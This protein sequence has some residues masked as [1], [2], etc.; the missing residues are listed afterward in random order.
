M[1]ETFRQHVE[2]LHP[3]FE[4]LV[5]AAPFRYADLPRQPVPRQGVYLLTEHGRH[6]YAGRSDNIRQRLRNHCA[7]SATHKTAAFAFRLTREAC[8]VLKASYRPEGSRAD[9]M[10]QEHF[11]TAFE[12]QKARLREMDIRVVEETNPNRQALL[13]MYVSIALATPYNDFAN[14]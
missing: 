4:L 8:G 7:V 3:A 13:E 9:L 6:L 11:R 14:H 10:T 5:A 2:A 12:A 1:N